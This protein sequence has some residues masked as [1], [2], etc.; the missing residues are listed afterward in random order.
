MA[1]MDHLSI[2][3]TSFFFLSFFF[4]LILFF[5]QAPL[6]VHFM[7]IVHLLLQ[8]KEK[9]EYA[10]ELKKAESE[11]ERTRQK[12]VQFFGEYI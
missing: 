4:C 12:L 2:C 8:E 6:L 9:P 5:H 10:I 7:V 11:Y 1:S 3:S